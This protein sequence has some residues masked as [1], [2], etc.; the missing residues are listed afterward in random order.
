MK[1]LVL[2]RG[3]PGAGKTTFAQTI[4]GK[5]NV[6]SADD[7]FTDLSGNYTFIPSQIQE[8]HSV[9]LGNVRQRMISDSYSDNPSIIAVA[10]TFTQDWEMDKY[11]YIAKEFGYMVHSVI[12]ENRHGGTNIH[13]VPES[14]VQAMKDR[15]SVKL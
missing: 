9:C 10:N 3:C 14:K 13:N 6:Y 1:V 2:V 4:V 11:F 12:V 15:F 8:A 7:F 5:D